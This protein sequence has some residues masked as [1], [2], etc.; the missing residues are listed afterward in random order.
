MV[1]FVP[2]P[3]PPTTFLALWEQGAVS[4]NWDPSA[5]DT[6]PSEIVGDGCLHVCMFVWIDGLMN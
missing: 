5:P 4:P 2:Y 1:V 3:F 6:K